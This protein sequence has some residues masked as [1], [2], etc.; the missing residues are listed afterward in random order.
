DDGTRL[1]I[2]S[3][4]CLHRYLKKIIKD[5]FHALLEVEAPQFKMK[6]QISSCRSLACSFEVCSL[7]KTFG[8]FRLK[9]N[10]LNAYIG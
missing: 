10:Y 1:S 3:F 5:K 2:C 7:Y 6:S 4:A 8:R 9:V